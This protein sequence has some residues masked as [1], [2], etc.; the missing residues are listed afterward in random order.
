[1]TE[2]YLMSWGNN[3][4]TLFNRKEEVTS[5]KRDHNVLRVPVVTASENL[6][7][8]TGNKIGGEGEEPGHWKRDHAA[9]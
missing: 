1:M 3:V 7:P 2:V 4:L 6:A 8:G 9:S 5:T